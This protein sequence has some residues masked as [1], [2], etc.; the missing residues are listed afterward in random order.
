MRV[1]VFARERTSGETAASDSSSR[2]GGGACLSG[3]KTAAARALAGVAAAS[4]KLSRTSCSAIRAPSATG[5]DA[6]AAVAGTGARAAGGLGIGMRVGSS[7][8][9][10]IAGVESSALFLFVSRQ[11][12]L[13]LSLP[14]YGCS[15]FQ[16]HATL[17][18]RTELF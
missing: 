13:F 18:A 4:C 14:L 6:T 12:P 7:S 17:V 8:S 11:V 2:L 3:V 5:D 9:S 10:C 1:C 15:V 16:Q